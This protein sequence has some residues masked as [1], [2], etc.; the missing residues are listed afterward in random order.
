MPKSTINFS[1]PQRKRF[2][3]R[4]LG[5]YDT[6][7]RHLPWRYAPGDVADPYRVWLSEVML[8]QTQV[9][10]VIPYFEK[11][12]ARWPTVTALA[13]ASEEDVLQ[14]WA[15][16]GYYSRGR[17]LRKCA[18]VIVDEH[19][20]IFPKDEKQLKK[21]PGIGDYTAAA[22][23]T[24]AFN[25]K[26]TVVDGNIERIMGRLFC[27]DVPL[28]QSKPLLKLAAQPFFE[29]TGRPGDLAQALMD[30]GAT[31]CTPKSPKCLLC[32]LQ[33]DCKAYQAG[34][35]E[36]YP[37]KALKKAKP[38]KYGY[39]YVIQDGQGNVALQRRAEKGMLAGTLGVPTSD[40]LEEEKMLSHSQAVKKPKA[41]QITIQHSFTHF[42]LSLSLFSAE[43]AL[44]KFDWHP[45]NDE[46]IAGLPTLF[47]KAL[48]QVAQDL[49]QAV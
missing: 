40:W 13:N 44:N 49:G 23:R 31:I 45:L 7:R 43:Q 18:K 38:K 42:D 48:K 30:I 14:Q 26:A 10:T 2:I 19:Q 21:L 20:G 12:T 8:Q 47:Q 36:V 46:T 39:L 35:M 27:V 15:G 25:G 29:M 37:V 22:I 4:L 9:T 17:N 24:I 11:F 34:A 6:H 16:L 5:W 32:P 1:T 41:M 3:Q 33:A 28:P